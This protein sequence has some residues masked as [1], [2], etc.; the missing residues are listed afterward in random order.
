MM[1]VLCSKSMALKWAYAVK[2]IL[3][4]ARKAG[5]TPWLTK[6]SVQSFLQPV[7][8]MERL[9]GSSLTT[10]IKATAFF[11]PVMPE[12]MRMTQIRELLL[13]ERDQASTSNGLQKLPI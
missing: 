2:A 10:K 5:W 4:R 13:K 9:Q 11:G 6:K 8:T 1:H 3:G 7:A 12:Y